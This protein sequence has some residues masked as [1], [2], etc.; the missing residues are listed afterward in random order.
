[1]GD[2]IKG[3]NATRR[4]WNKRAPEVLDTNQREGWVSLDINISQVTFFGRAGGT[5]ELQL[6][7]CPTMQFK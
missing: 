5:S 3:F 4:P 6:G 1:M 7:D 2:P